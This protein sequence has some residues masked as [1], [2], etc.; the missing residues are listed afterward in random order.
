MASAQQPFAVWQPN[1]E[2]RGRNSGTQGSVNDRYCAHCKAPREYLQKTQKVPDKVYCPECFRSQGVT[3]SGLRMRPNK[4]EKKE[5]QRLKEEGRAR[6]TAA[7]SANLQAIRVAKLEDKPRPTQSKIDAKYDELMEQ[8]SGGQPAAGELFWRRLCGLICLC[9]CAICLLAVLY[10]PAVFMAFCY[11]WGC[12]PAKTGDVVAIPKEY[13]AWG[14]AVVNLVDKRCPGQ[15][16]PWAFCP[17][18]VLQRKKMTF[19]YDKDGNAFDSSYDEEERVDEYRVS[20]IP[21]NGEDPL[22][23]GAMYDPKRD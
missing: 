6:A 16:Y 19:P 5:A 2:R 12:I 22:M 9:N 10:S 8:I 1:G 14:V 13:I 18:K 20:F 4:E 21:G 23:P 15:R 3:T 11:L 17:I 7:Q